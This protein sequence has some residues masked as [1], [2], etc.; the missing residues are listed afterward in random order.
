MTGCGSEVS[1]ALYAATL[2]KTWNI[3]TSLLIH[4]EVP[5]LIITDTR[6]LLNAVFM[7]E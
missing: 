2:S 3:F 7:G 5:K 4:S 6:R 1:D